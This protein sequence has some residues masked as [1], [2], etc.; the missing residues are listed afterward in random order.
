M[1]C[2]FWNVGGWSTD[3]LSENHKL[4]SECVLSSDI[5]IIGIAET[6]LVLNK[7][8][9]VNGYSWFGHN[10]KSIHVK[11]KCG[12]G[13]VG[14]LVKNELCEQFNVSILDN[15]YEGILWLRL[16]HKES[17]ETIITACVCYLPPE[18]STRYVDAH[19]FFDTLLLQLHNYH[20][21]GVTYVCGDFNSRC[22]NLLDYVED[23]DALSNRDVR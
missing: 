1:L 17:S 2:G 23:V 21:S 15:S 5:D 14:F 12:S 18:Y 4:R 10:R 3:P 7:V 19:D 22:G 6:H 11:A 20:S 9:T 8:V 16:T 13:G